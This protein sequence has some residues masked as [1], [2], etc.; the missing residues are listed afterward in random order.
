VTL[1]GPTA[2]PL[3]TPSEYLNPRTAEGLLPW[4]YARERLELARNFWLATTRPDGRPHVTPLW[5]AWIDDMLYFDGSPETRWGRNISR[6]PAASINL[7]NGDRVVIVEGG[8]ENLTT[9]E[10]LAARLI[11]AWASKYGQYP[12]EPAT[13]GIFRLRPTTARGWT[14]GSLIDGTRWTFAR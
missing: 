1:I 3:H 4:S 14:H 10:E 2:S 12:P 5:G 8:I 9:D 6:N 11:A 13:R 7:S